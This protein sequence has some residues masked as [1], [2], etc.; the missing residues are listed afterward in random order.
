MSDM[1][2]AEDLNW[3]GLVKDRT[4]TDLK[5]LNDPK[6]YYLGVDCSANSLT[7]GNLA[8]FLLAKRLISAG[9]KSVLLVGGATSMIGDPGGKDEER[10]LMSRDQISVNVAAI[11][12]QVTQLF[13]GQEFLLVDNYDWFK[14]MKY[15][16][17]LR[18]VGK[19]YSMTELIQR[20]FISERMGEHGSGISYA[21]FS[22]TLIQGYD[23]WHLFKEH[24]VVLQIGG[25]DQWGNMLSGVPLI[26]KKAGQEVH[27]MSMPLII[28]KATGKKF[29]KSE[30]GTIWLDSKKTSVLDFYQFWINVEDLDVPEYLKVFTELGRGEIGRVIEQHQNNPSARYAQTVLADEVTK[31]VHGE[32]A[33]EQAKQATAVLVSGDVGAEGSYSGLPSRKVSAPVDL[34]DLLIQTGLAVSK[35][36]ARRL[37]EG[38][39]IYIDGQT[40]K[41][42]SL[43]IDDFKDGRII[44]RRGKAL[45]DSVLIELAG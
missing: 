32:A 21:E 34:V 29:G 12:A 38:G 44:I 7:V 30:S 4:F 26:R 25:S 18:D 33:A 17:F 8:V 20:D 13:S 39:G 1:T 35:T 45:K 2:F 42:D 19:N 14:D 9:W 28:N 40:A 5:W 27:A 31:L 43:E 36:E 6:T 15:L 41:K 24:G 3:R 22:Y 16:E 11:E 10:Q 37:I 23:Y